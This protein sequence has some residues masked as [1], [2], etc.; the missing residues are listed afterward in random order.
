MTSMAGQKDQGRLPPS[1]ADALETEMVGRNVLNGR[2]T[3]Q[4]VE[5]F[6][7]T[8][9]LPF[10]AA[11]QRVR[12]ELMDGVRHLHEARMKEQRRTHGHPDH[13]ENP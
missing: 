4:V 2:W 12:D 6:D 8:Y 5:E 11:D 13:T 9:W 10:R 7:D 3:F 1:L